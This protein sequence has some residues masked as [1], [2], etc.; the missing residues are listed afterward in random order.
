MKVGGLQGQDGERL[1]RLLI[2][3]VQSSASMMVLELSI[4]ESAEDSINS[5]TTDGFKDG[6]VLGGELGIDRS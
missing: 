4:N 3:W 6:S 5:G 2:A 1:R